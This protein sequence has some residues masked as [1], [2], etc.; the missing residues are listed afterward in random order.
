MA[1]RGW[2]EAKDI[3]NTQPLKDFKAALKGRA[4]AVRGL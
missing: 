2:C 1:R 3:L 4:M